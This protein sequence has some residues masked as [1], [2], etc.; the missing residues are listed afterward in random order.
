MSAFRVSGWSNRKVLIPLVTK[1]FAREFSSYGMLALK[2]AREAVQR[3]ADATVSEGLDI[4]A[5]LNPL[6]FETEDATEG[7]RVVGRWRRRGRMR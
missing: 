7:I 6:A 5:D 2:F 1:S 3:A 4:E